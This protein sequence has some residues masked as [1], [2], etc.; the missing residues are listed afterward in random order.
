LSTGIAL[1]DT[2]TG[3]PT[4][5]AQ[6][7]TVVTGGCDGLYWHDGDLFGIQN[8]TNPGRVVIIALGDNGARIVGLTVLQSRHHPDF[9]EPTTGT[10]R[11]DMLYVIGNSYVGHYQPDGTIKDAGELKGTAIIGVPLHRWWESGAGDDEHGGR[12]SPGT[13]TK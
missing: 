9:S 4:R 6:P 13:D 10:I 3:D 12:R 2:S 5:L 1:V 8:T 11:G 7:D